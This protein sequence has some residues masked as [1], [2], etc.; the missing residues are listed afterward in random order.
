MPP[1]W[2]ELLSDWLIELTD[3]GV[4]AEP[5][6]SMAQV[7]AYCTSPPQVERVAAEVQRRWAELAPPYELPPTL[8]VTVETISEEDWAHSWKAY[9]HAL[10]IGERLVV[11]PSWETWPP[12]DQPE[13]AHP[14]DTVIEMDPEM[15]FGT[16]THETTR[17]CLELLE[18][19]LRPRDTVA[20]VGA[21]SGILSIAAALLGSGPV[22]AW[23][24]DP[25]AAEVAH[26]NCLRNGVAR[27]CT[28]ETGDA[29]K[30]L[31]G[32]YDL[33]V[34]NVHTPFLLRLIPRLAEYLR[35]EGRV[36]LSGASET[37]RPALL[38]ALAEAGLEVLEESRRGEWLALAAT[39]ASLR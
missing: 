33:L 20:D 14:D 4:S 10:R 9:Y 5:A 24:V 23:E 28:V 27:Q 30:N 38:A 3:R 37:S 22:R 36:I 19:Y 13:Q 25:V 32:R 8:P 11:K 15:A 16:G 39:A 26:R 18:R 35:P 34:A 7:T 31:S 29:L 2:E 17:M 21:G 1:E 12:A 6:A